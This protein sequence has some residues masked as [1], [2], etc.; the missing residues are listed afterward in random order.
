MRRDFGQLGLADGLIRQ[1]KLKSGWLNEIERSIDWASI[2]QLLGEI[3]AQPMVG[4]VY[5]ILNY[6]RLL[7]LKQW[8]GLSDEGLKAAVDDRQSFCRFA[9][10][11][12]GQS[13]PDHRCQII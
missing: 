8:Y 2:E 4:H 5:P 7:L 10:I 1:R 13:V 11:P 12:L 3:Y 6:L 9:G